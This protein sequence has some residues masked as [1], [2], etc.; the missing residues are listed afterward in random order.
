MALI[1]AAVALLLTGFLSVVSF[2]TADL[3]MEGVET[4]VDP[5]RC[6][7]IWNDP[8]AAAGALETP[9]AGSKRED[10]GGRGLEK[11]FPLEVAA[12]G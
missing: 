12:A 4:Q 1:L 9:R 6:G 3:R 5:L 10:G 8:T 11:L 2:Q 7:R